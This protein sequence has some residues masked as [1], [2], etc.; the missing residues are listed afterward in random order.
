[1]KWGISVKT[2]PSGWVLL[3]SAWAGTLS[4]IFAVA[5]YWIHRSQ[6]NEAL[7]FL[8]IQL[9]VECR[10]LYKVLSDDIIQYGQIRESEYSKPFHRKVYRK[11]IAEYLLKTGKFVEM[12]DSREAMADFLLIIQNIDLINSVD[13]RGLQRSSRKIVDHFFNHRLVML[14]ERLIELS[15]YVDFVFL[16]IVPKNIYGKE[17][18]QKNAKTYETLR[19]KEDLVLEIMGKYS[20]FYGFRRLPDQKI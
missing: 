8:K 1:M 17:E 3:L 16:G 12:F 19:K 18:A 2:G 15:E 6:E 10:T 11:D 7:D 20:S 9:N 13:E 14:R 5:T 4:L